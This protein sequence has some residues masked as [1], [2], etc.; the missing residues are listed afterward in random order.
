[1]I[2]WAIS[3]SFR[4]N[5]ALYKFTCLLTLIYLGAVSTNEKGDEP[6]TKHFNTL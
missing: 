4:G 6:K 3:E 1:M 2:P 5:K